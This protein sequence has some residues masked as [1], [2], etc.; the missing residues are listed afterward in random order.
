MKRHM[1]VLF[2]VLALAGI[3][4]GGALSSGA[5]AGEPKVQVCHRPPGNPNNYHTI[6]IGAPA[7]PAHLAHGDLVGACLDLCAT[8]CND[9]NLCTADSGVPNNETGQCECD[10]SPVN[11]DDSNVCTT[12]S[13]EPATGCHNVA[14]TGAACNDARFCTGP[15]VCTASGQ[16]AGAS[17]PFCCESDADCTAPSLCASATCNLATHGCDIQQKVCVAPDP[18]TV[19]ACNPTTGDCE[20]TPVICPADPCNTA[21]C[22]PTNGT[23]VQTPIAGCCTSDDDCASVEVCV[24]GTCQPLAGC[25]HSTIFTVCGTSTIEICQTV[26]A[27]GFPVSFVPDAVC[28]GTTGMCD[29]VDT[30]GDCCQT[31]LLPN[32]AFCYEGFALAV[33]D[34]ANLGGTVYPGQSCTA[35]GCQ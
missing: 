34:C 25:C 18:C 29:T 7:L 17:I 28:N 4:A 2:P 24:A 10:S 6:T 1:R 8:L 3:I 11:C 9:G 30:G 33:V 13:C 5:A 27:L 12:D 22:D 19:S 20:S 16:C 15:D 21:A 26:S 31:P 35:Q 23:C 32:G 14:N